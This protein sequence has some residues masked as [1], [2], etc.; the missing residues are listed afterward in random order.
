MC[1]GTKSL[2]CQMVQHESGELELRLSLGDFILQTV[3][4]HERISFLSKE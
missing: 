3:K 4:G 1:S 2:C